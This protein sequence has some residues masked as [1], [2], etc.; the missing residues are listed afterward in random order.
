MAQKAL[1]VSSLIIGIDLAS[2]RPI[3]GVRTIVGDITTQKARQVSRVIKAHCTQI[4][5]R[6]IMTA[7]VLPTCQFP[8]QSL[9][10]HAG[11]ARAS[12]LAIHA[13]L[14]HILEYRDAIDF[15]F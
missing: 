2:I 14:Q 3:R 4:A 15:S 13:T 5:A 10:R 11:I 9:A 12:L 8:G 6:M 1:P 7:T